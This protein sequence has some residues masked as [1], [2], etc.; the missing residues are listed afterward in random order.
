MRRELQCLSRNDSIGSVVLAASSSARASLFVVRWLLASPRVSSWPAPHS[1]LVE[2]KNPP[3]SP[4]RSSQLNRWPRQ[5]Y[6]PGCRPKTSPVGTDLRAVRPRRR[7]AFGEIAL[8]PELAGPWPACSKIRVPSPNNFR[9]RDRSPSGPSPQTRRFRRH[10]PTRVACR[11]MLNRNHA[12]GP[13]VLAASSSARASVFFGSGPQRAPHHG[14]R[15][16]LGSSCERI[17]CAITGLPPASCRR[18]PLWLVGAKG[19]LWMSD[20][21]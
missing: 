3:G 1:C 14:P 12:L 6:N 7:G 11:G 17:R 15:L 9:G 5:W 13:V 10:R 19:G 21:G 16:T 4:S 20:M 8:P 2:Q 18:S